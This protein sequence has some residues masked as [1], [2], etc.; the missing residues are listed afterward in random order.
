MP[1]RRTGCG[2]RSDRAPRHHHLGL[3]RRSP[4]GL[5][6]LLD[7]TASPLVRPYLV[8][9]EQERSRQPKLAVVVDSE[10]HIACTRGAA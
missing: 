5:D 6:T 3:D 7:G 2:P 1:Q 10:Q 9:V 8:A 4:Y